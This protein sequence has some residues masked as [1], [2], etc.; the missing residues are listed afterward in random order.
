MRWLPYETWTEQSSLDPPALAEELRKRIHKPKIRFSL[1]SET[2]KGLEGRVFKKSFEVHRAIG[3]R[4]SFLPIISGRLIP[5]AGG[6]KV[7]IK[8]TLHPFVLAFLF[9]AG[10]FLG[11]MAAAVFFGSDHAYEPSALPPFL[12]MGGFMA[13]LTYGGFFAEA[14]RSRAL[15]EELFRQVEEEAGGARNESGQASA[16]PPPLP[17]APV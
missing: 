14:G 1:F 7:R 10:G 15:A 3:Y 8:M 5:H 6:T 9:Y 12:G 4:N 11:I 2:G 13:L 16:G 17:L